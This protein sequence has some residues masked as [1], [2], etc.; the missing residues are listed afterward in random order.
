MARPEGRLRWSEQ[1]S[2]MIPDFAKANQ[3]KTGVGSA[4]WGDPRLK[5]NVAKYMYFPVIIWSTK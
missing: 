3:E 1:K 4:I 5:N 2:R